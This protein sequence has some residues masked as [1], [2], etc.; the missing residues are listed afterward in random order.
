MNRYTDAALKKKCPSW[1]YE[2][3]KQH[4]DSAA[5][6]T[7]LVALKNICKIFEERISSLHR[8]IK[9]KCT[10]PIA[11]AYMDVSYLT[12]TLGNNGFNR[13]YFYCGL[14]GKQTFTKDN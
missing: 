3:F 1:L 6:P 7:E 8:E 2:E 10:H 11:T 5:P 9:D 12:D 4:V 14:C 13:Y